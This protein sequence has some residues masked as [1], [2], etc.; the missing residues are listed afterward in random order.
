MH[1]LRREFD[2]D[3]VRRLIMADSS[4][5]RLYKGMPLDLALLSEERTRIVHRLQNS[6]Y[7]NR[8]Q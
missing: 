6:G 4:A 7:M 2:N 5:S 1:E 8:Q 3:T